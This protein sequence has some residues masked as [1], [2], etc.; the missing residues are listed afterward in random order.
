MKAE[1]SHTIPRPQHQ[2]MVTILISAG[3]HAG[4]VFMLIVGGLLQRSPSNLREKAIITRL[5]KKGKERPKNFL[6][7]KP[8][9]AP[10]AAPVPAPS[11]SKKET[12]KPGEKTA[13]AKKNDYSKQMNKALAALE[14][15]GEGKPS[16]DQ[17]EGSP[18]GV[19]EGDALIAQLGDVYLTQVY[20]LVKSNYAVPEIIS[21]RERMFLQA[22]V[23]ITLDAKGN[24]LELG[25]EKRSGNG[26]FDS[27]IENAIRKTAPFP[28]PPKELAGKYRSDGI[29]MN[30]RASRM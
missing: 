17:P 4:L 27:A 10:A 5:L 11:P 2:V 25:F 19:D 14:K 3:V 7:R 22:T 1:H 20:K 21:E 16:K 13:P 24:I 18:D 15:T 29:G 9:E 8:E 6:P 26:V 23:V 12:A 30:F 28:A